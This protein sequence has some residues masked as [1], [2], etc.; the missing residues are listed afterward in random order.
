MKFGNTS[1]IKI[2]ELRHSGGDLC[3]KILSKVGND[4]YECEV[5][6][7]PSHKHLGKDKPSIWDTSFLLS[8]LLC[9]PEPV[10]CKICKIEKCSNCG[11]FENLDFICFKC[12]A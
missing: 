9:G 8:F 5:L 7:H 11:I 2:G 4:L 1:T 12:H 10:K 6:H 3:L